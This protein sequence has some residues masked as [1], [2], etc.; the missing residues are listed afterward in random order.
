ME[1]DTET[2]GASRID[3]DTAW[4]IGVGRSG[5]RCEEGDRYW[6]KC[7]WYYVEVNLV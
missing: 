4:F 7:I 3:A 5:R 6:N 1:H 2:E